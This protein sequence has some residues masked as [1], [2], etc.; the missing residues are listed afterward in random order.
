MTLQHKSV[1]KLTSMIISLV[2]FPLPMAVCAVHT[3]HKHPITVK[4]SYYDPSQYPVTNFMLDFVEKFVAD[5]SVPTFFFISGLLFFANGMSTDIFKNK[6]RHR[7]SSLLLPYIV[8]NLIAVGF[9]AMLYLPVVKHW[10]P[11]LADKTFDM[12]WM[13]FFRGFT[14]GNDINSLPHAGTMWFIR[15]L[16]TVML[17][18]PLISLAINKLKWIPLA[19]FYLFWAICFVGKATIY[20]QFFSSALMFFSLGVYFSK[21]G[22][23]PA[24]RF[25]SRLRPALIIFLIIGIT[26]MVLTYIGF[27]DIYTRLLKTVS[28]PCALIVVFAIAGMYGRENGVR[29]KLF[30]N[31]P[32]FSTLLPGLSFFIFVAHGIF[33]W[34]F[35]LVTFAVIR[36]TSDLALA[37]AYIATYIGI[38]AAL[39]GLYLLIGKASPR[40]LRILTGR[41]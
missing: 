31:V 21:C 30:G 35:Q 9:F 20:L 40:L 13:E 18:S 36:P 32:P 34:H 19:A 4:G 29:Q 15:E 1:S 33:L 7:C 14:I 38:L 26:G 24:E 16:M 3:F 28:V 41:S 22:V 10:L 12:T 37:A 27:D 39:T 23:D 17:L 2:R 6:L 11:S 25:T 5:F 8:W